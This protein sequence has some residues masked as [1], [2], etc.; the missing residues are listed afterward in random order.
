[1]APG[2]LNGST[3]TNLTTGDTERGLASG[4]NHLY[5]VSR[6]GGD[7]IRILDA[8]TGADLGALNLGSNIVSG[9][10]F[11]VNMVAVAADGVIYVV[12][13][14]IGPIAFRVYRWTDDLPSTTPR[15]AYSGVPLAGA[16]IGDSLAVMGSG[17][18]TRLVAGFN[19]A[20]SV[21]GNNGYAVIDPTAGTA[22]AVGFSSL[23]PG[24]GDFRLG[25]SFIDSSHVIGTQGGPGNPV[26]YTSFSESSGT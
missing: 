3:Y 14:A 22:T 18:S 2:G 20:P 5:L 13:L 8:Q 6:K 23:P 16:R 9:G 12:N 26:C 19:S 10:T 21:S 25:V 1:L 24:P 11:N 7:S 17:S 15:V 4:N